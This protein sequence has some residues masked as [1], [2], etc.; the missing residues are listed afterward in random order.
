MK[1]T[2][3]IAALDKVAPALATGDL[4]PILTHFWFTG[5]HVLGYNDH[6]ALMT[7]CKTDF[8]AAVPGMTL[9]NV[10][11]ASKAP[12]VEFK[13]HDGELTVKLASA[14]ARLQT[15]PRKQYEAHFKMPEKGE[16]HIKVDGK[17]LKAALTC[18]LRSVSIDTTIPDQLG[19][20]ILPTKNN[21]LFYSTDNATL[22]HARIP[23]KDGGDMPERAILSAHFCREALSL[24]ETKKAPHIEVHDKY[25]LF[26]AADG[27]SLFGKLIKSEKP[28]DFANSLEHHY[29][30]GSREKLVTMPTKLELVVDRA[31]VVLNTG[32][33]RVHT[34]IVV[35]GGKATFSTK[36]KSIEMD[37][38]LAPLDQADVKLRVNPKLLKNGM[39]SFDKMLIL[40][41]CFVMASNELLYVISADGAE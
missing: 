20:T 14:T 4:I 9:L 29:P 33:G 31:C 7:P 36:S 5:T 2:E 17:L 26:F 27:T 28:L 35:R 22:S 15:M 11:K 13:M 24:I 6:V 25:A 16:S 21:L 30:K 40:P 39:G 3:L 37:D 19:V 32:M 12:D 38:M 18:C 8:V 1:R 34:D 41:R 23:Y 10:L